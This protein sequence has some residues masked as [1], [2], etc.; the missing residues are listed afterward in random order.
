MET[1]SWVQAASRMLY[2]MNTQ[3]HDII[4]SSKFIVK[5]GLFLNIS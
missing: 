4:L 5:N 2:A 3:F 1:I